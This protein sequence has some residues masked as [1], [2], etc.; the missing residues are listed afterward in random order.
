MATEE[1]SNVSFIQVPSSEKGVHSP[2]WV[3]LKPARGLAE[4]SFVGHAKTLWPAAL[5]Y[6]G[7]SECLSLSST[8]MVDITVCLAREDK[9]TFIR[10]I[11]IIKSVITTDLEQ[12]TLSS[13]L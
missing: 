3:H 7:S 13:E 8:E 10:N 11:C 9:N 5:I 4:A 6:T 12:L 1:G 2:G